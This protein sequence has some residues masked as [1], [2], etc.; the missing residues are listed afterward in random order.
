MAPLPYFC[1]SVHS[2]RPYGIN[3]CR[4]LVREAARA[5]VLE[6]AERGIRQAANFALELFFA[7][8]KWVGRPDFRPGGRRIPVGAVAFVVVGVGTACRIGPSDSRGNRKRQREVR[9]RRAAGSAGVRTRFPIPPG[10]R[11][12]KVS[13]IARQRCGRS[14]RLTDCGSDGRRAASCRIRSRRRFGSLGGRAWRG[15]ARSGCVTFVAK[16]GLMGW[17]SYDRKASGGSDGSG[18]AAVRSWP[19]RIVRWR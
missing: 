1:V 13:R 12:Y 3:F 19:A 8:W 17:P 10:R 9:M 5:L 7:T 2:K 15:T 6:A 14:L 18:P 4:P 16:G 11:R